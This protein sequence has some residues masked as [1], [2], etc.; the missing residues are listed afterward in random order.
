[1]LFTWMSCPYTLGQ[2]FTSSWSSKTFNQVI[3]HQLYFY[4]KASAILHSCKWS[5]GLSLLL[6][7]LLYWEVEILGLYILWN[8]IL[9]TIV[10]A[11]IVLLLAVLIILL[12]QVISWLLNNLL[13]LLPVNLW[14]PWFE[15]SSLYALE[16]VSQALSCPKWFV[17]AL[18]WGITELISIVTSMAVSATAWYSEHIQLI[19]SV[20]YPMVFHWH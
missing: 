4:Q 18:I 17:A 10:P 2:S 9:L 6:L 3:C 19:M 20:I 7:L 11:L 15:D 13:F 8:R 1:M 14:L 16:T 12:L 5:S